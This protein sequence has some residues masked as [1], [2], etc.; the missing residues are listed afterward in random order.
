LQKRR[1]GHFRISRPLGYFNRTHQ[2]G[3]NRRGISRAEPNATVF[4]SRLKKARNSKSSQ[5]R[6]GYWI[7]A[8]AIALETVGC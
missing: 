1:L 6:L 4:V 5:R 2:L 8:A 7:K 3:P